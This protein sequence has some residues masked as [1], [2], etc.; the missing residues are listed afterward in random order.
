MRASH[1]RFGILG[2]GPG[3][4]YRGMADLHEPDGHGG[5]YTTG[6]ECDHHHLTPEAA[7]ACARATTKAMAAGQADQEA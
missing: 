5:E 4:T 2:G 3:T 7:T 6:W 1:L